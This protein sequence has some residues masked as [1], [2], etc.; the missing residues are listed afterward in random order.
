MENRGFEFG[1]VKGFF[2]LQNVRAR[3]WEP[4]LKVK[5][6][7]SKAERFSPPPPYLPSWLYSGIFMFHKQTESH[8]LLGT[9]QN[10]GS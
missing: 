5:R 7:K 2:M 1:R 10:G 4:F 6:Q 8:K 3:F 9:V